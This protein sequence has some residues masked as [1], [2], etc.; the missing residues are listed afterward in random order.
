MKKYIKGTN[1]IGLVKGLREVELVKEINSNE[2][3]HIKKLEGTEIYITLKM[4]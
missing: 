2:V 4:K 1:L 3:Y